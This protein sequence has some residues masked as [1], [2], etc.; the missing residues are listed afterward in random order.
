M[1]TKPQPVVDRVAK[2]FY[3]ILGVTGAITF[4]LI[5]VGAA[6][7]FF[8]DHSFGWRIV[9]L[10]LVVFMP[11]MSYGTFEWLRELR[12]TNDLPG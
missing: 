8:L 6:V 5:A 10:V 11:L 9:M 4:A 1:D 7:G 12:R 2:T 3:T